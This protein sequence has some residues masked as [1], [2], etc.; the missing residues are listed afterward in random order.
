ME[1][2][3]IEELKLISYEEKISYKKEIEDIYEKEKSKYLDDAEYKYR[4]N[5]AI[6]KGI[7]RHHVMLN[8]EYC[9]VHEIL[10]AGCNLQSL[11]IFLSEN[12]EFY[13]PE[14]N[15]QGWKVAPENFGYHNR[16]IARIIFNI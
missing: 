14:G 9:P 5:E 11:I 2:K 4:M 13:I 8:H 12:K 10:D 6:I 7:I 1:K 15:P 3:F 16:W